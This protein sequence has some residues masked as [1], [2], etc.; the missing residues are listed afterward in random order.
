MFGRAD[1]KPFTC[2]LDTPNDPIIC[3]S[4]DAMEHNLKTY[5]IPIRPKVSRIMRSDSVEPLMEGVPPQELVWCIAMGFPFAN[6]EVVFRGS[7]VYDMSLQAFR[8][9]LGA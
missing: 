6:V 2:H 4:I 8:I 1:R 7:R 5:V 9:P 3:H